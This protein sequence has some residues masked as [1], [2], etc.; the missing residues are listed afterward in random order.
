MHKAELG[1][2]YIFVLGLE[3]VLALLFWVL[4]FKENYSFLK[5]L[6]V[7]LIVAG[8]IFLRAVRVKKM[9]CLKF[10]VK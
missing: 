4:I 5:L 3:F 2:T 7:S 9:Y 6:G 1:V 8:M 10:M